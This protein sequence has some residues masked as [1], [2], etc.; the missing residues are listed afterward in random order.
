MEKL[1]TP[2]QLALLPFQRLFLPS[3]Q[4]DGDLFPFRTIFASILLLACFPEVSY[5]SSSRVSSRTLRQHGG[6]S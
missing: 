5:H 3:L 1:K 6:Q 4:V 2:Q